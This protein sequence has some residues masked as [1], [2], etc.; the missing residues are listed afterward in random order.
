LEL[1]AA[2]RETYLHTAT[3]GDP[4][5]LREV[6]TLLTSHAKAGAFLDRP[7]WAVEPELAFGDDHS[8]VGKQIGTY[9]ILEEIGRGGMGV[10]YA[11]EDQRLRRAVALKA[12]TPEYTR[13]PRRP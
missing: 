7:A 11:A 1:D 13:D 9:R 8:L 10:V 12:L 4:E 5:L 3:A 2:G 6:R